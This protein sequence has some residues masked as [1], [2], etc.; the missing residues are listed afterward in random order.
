MRRTEALRVP[1]LLERDTYPRENLTGRRSLPSV[2]AGMFS[3]LAGRVPTIAYSLR[4]FSDKMKLSTQL[5][6]IPIFVV[7]NEDAPVIGAAH[8]ALAV[9]CATK[10][11]SHS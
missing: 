7:L 2:E 10:Q 3:N 1:L 9:S 8:E 6:K 11:A 4:A 5:A